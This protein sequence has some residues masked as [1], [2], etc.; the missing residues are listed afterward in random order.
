MLKRAL[1]LGVASLA[2]LSFAALEA[3]AQSSGNGSS[4]NAPSSNAPPAAASPAPTSQHVDLPPLSA[5]PPTNPDGSP[6]QSISGTVTSPHGPEAGVW[7]IAETTELPTKFV[8]IVVTDDKGRYLLPQLPRADYS[9]WVRGYGLVDS[10]K[11]HGVPGK[12]LD[13]GA[14][15]AP[16]AG[17]AAQYYPAIYWYSMLKIPGANQFG[18]KS[19]IPPKATLQQ[20]L[21]DIK[22]QGCVGCH[23]LGM[24]STRTIPAAFS[25]L[26]PEQA[27]IRR[28]QSGQSASQMVGAAGAMGGVPLHYFADWTERIA[29]GALPTEKPQR[30]QGMERNVVITEWEWG[31]PSTYLHDLISTDKRNPTVNAY[32]PLVGSTEYSTDD[33]PI[34]DPKT[35]TAYTFHAPHRD[36]DM[37]ES[38]GPGQAADLKPMQPSAY[39]GDH[40]MWSNY[41]NNHNSMFDSQGRLWLTADFRNKA[42]PAYCKQ[43]SDL[44]SAKIFP[45]TENTRQL[46]M[47]DLKTG[48]YTFIDT[49]F[50]WQHLNFGRDKDDTLYASGGGPVLGWVDT[51]TFDETHDAAK[52]QGWTPLIVDADGNGKRDAYVDFNQPTDPAKDKRLPGGFYAVM[53]S[54]ADGSVWGTVGVFGPG[55]GLVRVAL[56][57]DAPANA[58]SE[59]YAIPAPGFGP[60]GGDIDTKGRVWVSLGSGQLG[61][62]D[63]SKCKGPLN[64]AKGA[65]GTACPEGWSFFQYPGPGFAGI[66]KNSAEASYYT[67]VD[68]LDT[69][70]L[71]KDVPISTG[72]ENDALLA[73][74]NGKWVVMRVP[75]P[76]SFYTKGL[77]GRI[78]DPKGGW[79]ARGVWTTSGD[80]T[81]W[82]HE[83]GKGTRPMAFHFQIRPNP[84]AD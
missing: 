22:N 27:W 81:P 74:V 79:K 56:G 82:L 31:S 61:E 19:S 78:D 2:L 70:G 30:P 43:G 18:G 36:A 50:G 17:D 14:V 29:K 26:D 10:P 44:E 77:D 45:L 4:G 64:G 54:P 16:N 47:L 71:G 62:F 83:G 32:G 66:G 48:T 35:N 51:K 57:S 75:Y 63:R 73:L 34:L 25:D 46:A 68:Q 6:L 72:N 8:K 39:W 53:T 3:A 55:P 13:L 12:H 28:I 15:P 20:Y 60:R 59:Y 80:R 58:M 67:W 9:V 42:D 33:L 24:L 65:D 76:M 41:I 84:L 69:L 40:K 52:S 7:V 1:Y 38:L 5:G 11:V 21:T 23:Q 37:P 49:C